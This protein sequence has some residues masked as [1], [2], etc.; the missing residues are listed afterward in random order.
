MGPALETARACVLEHFDARDGL[1]AAALLGRMIASRGGSASFLSSELDTLAPFVSPD[2][3]AT[4]RAA[5]FEGYAQAMAEESMASR[6]ATWD[7]PACVVSLGEGHA[8]IAAG[9]PNDSPDALSAWADRVATWLVRAK[10]KRVTVSGTEPARLALE[11]ALS[12]VGVLV[13]ASR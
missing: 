3:L 6:D 5:L 2:T 9:F 13:D 8:A 12:T 7:P 11:E 10:I 1:N 4:L